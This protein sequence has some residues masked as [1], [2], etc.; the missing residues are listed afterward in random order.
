MKGIFI[1]GVVFA[2]GSVLLIVTNYEKLDVQRYGDIVKMKIEEL[3]TFCLGT[4]SRY[5]AVFSYDGKIYDKKI[6][7]SFCRRHH[8]GE[9]IDMK[10]LKGSSTILF[11]HESVTLNLA[12]FAVL[13][14]LG[15]VMIITQWKKM[16][17]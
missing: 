6:G 9:L 2:I 8:V 1:A 12:S 4:K 14:L 3:P 5:F 13:G 15:V 16:R 17:K 7:G 11:P 10:V